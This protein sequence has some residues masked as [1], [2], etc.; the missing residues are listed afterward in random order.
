[1]KRVD[2]QGPRIRPRDAIDGLR[3]YRLESP[4]GAAVP[5]IPSVKLNQ[6]ESP[7]DW[8]LELKQE[9]VRRVAARPWNRYPP[10][11]AEALRGALARS[12]GVA[13]ELVAVTNGS[14]EAILAL[15]ETFA[16]GKTVLPISP[17]YSM[18][19]PL[20]VVGGAAV[21][22]VSLRPDFSLDVPAMLEAAQ[23]PDVGMVYIASPNNP[24]GNAFARAGIEAILEAA[25]S[26]VVIDEAYAG[27]AP[28]SFLLDIDRYPHL[29]VIRTFSKAFALAGARVGWITAAESVIAA[30]RKALPPYNLNAFAQEAALVALTRPD[31]I[32]TRV[33][34]ILRE[35]ERVAEA[36][37]RIAGVIAY[38][39]DANFILFRTGLPASVLFTRL[40]QR[41][42]LVRDVSSQPMLD[43]CLRLTIG[44]PAENEQFL[45]ALR[46]SVV[47][48]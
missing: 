2:A 37:R 18:A 33:A 45:E 7:W 20:A 14:N 39:S 22:T 5:M 46:G 9:V 35:R 13:P 40:L 23:A 4:V 12:H 43:R 30:V 31:L 3:A 24:T 36:M 1:M 32:A 41:G 16:G 27:F 11:D 15:V 19:A 38:R 6:N 34:S 48:S 42:V 44:T 26:L 29:A 10:V 25:C 8:P 17:G 28:D 21:R 47:A